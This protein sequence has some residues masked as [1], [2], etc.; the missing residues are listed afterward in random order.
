MGVFQVIFKTKE[1]KYTRLYRYNKG[2]EQFLEL[3]EVSG[4]REITDV[5]KIMEGSELWKYTHFHN[6]SVNGSTP[7]CYCKDCV[8]R[9]IMEG[10]IIVRKQLSESSSE[11][12][13]RM[14]IKCGLC[15]ITEKC[16]FVKVRIIVICWFVY[17][18]KGCE[19]RHERV[20]SCVYK[21]TFG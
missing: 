2:A 4:I 5:A 8:V 17:G 13:G 20:C 15:T 9:K 10:S 19:P 12:Y 6:K 14:S 3:R 7:I 21:P 16:R 1:R 18:V 11:S